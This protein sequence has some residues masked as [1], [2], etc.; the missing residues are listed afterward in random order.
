M[1]A[2]T[3]LAVLVCLVCFL[4]GYLAFLATELIADGVRSMMQPCQESTALCD[5]QNAAP[6][7][8]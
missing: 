7:S 8:K 1:K 2:S 5:S 6:K 4:I 3:A